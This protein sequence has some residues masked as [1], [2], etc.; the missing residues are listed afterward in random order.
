LSLRARSF[1]WASGNVGGLGDVLAAADGDVGGHVF[2]AGEFVPRGEI[3]LIGGGGEGDLAGDAGLV[4]L[5]EW[6]RAGGASGADEGDGHL[7]P[8]CQ[9][10]R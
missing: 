7:R 1:I 2:H 9:R 3:E 5:D 4:N 10:R 8:G 6:E